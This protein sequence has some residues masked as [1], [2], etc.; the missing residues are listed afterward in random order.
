VVALE[1][2]RHDLSAYALA[3]GL[4]DTDMQATVRAADEAAFPDVERFRRVAAEH[5]FNAPAWVAEHILALAFGRT[6]P[7]SVTVRIPDQPVPHL[8]G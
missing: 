4:V 3:P 6:K 5:R 1:E 8:A 7:D 2:A